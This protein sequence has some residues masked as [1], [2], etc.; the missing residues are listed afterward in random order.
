MR[1]CA[2]VWVWFLL[3]QGLL[4]FLSSG[5]MGKG[6]FSSDEKSNTPLVGTNRYL[7]P[8]GQVLTPAGRQ[9]DL[10]GMRPQALALSPD[11]SMLAAAGSKDFFVL[12]DVAT[13]AVL[14]KVH[15]SIIQK[16]LK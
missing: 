11:G 1:R 15:L 13:G 7:T 4:V 14:Q 10:L 12:L 16:K 2:I 5:A 6:L 8:T 9:I 3:G